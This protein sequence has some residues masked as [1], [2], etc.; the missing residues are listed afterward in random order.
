V[1]S[2]AVVWLLAANTFIMVQYIACCQL[3]ERQPADAIPVGVGQAACAAASQHSAVAIA[4]Y[5]HQLVLIAQCQA[6][7]GMN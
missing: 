5:A 1:V 7:S 3:V 4:V 6:C 2:R